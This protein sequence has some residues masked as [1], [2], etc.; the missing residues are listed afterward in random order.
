MV[1]HIMKFYNKSHLKALIVFLM[2]L[3]DCPI[4]AVTTPWYT[5]YFHWLNGTNYRSNCSMID[6]V[7]K[8]QYAALVLYYQAT[9]KTTDFNNA[10]LNIINDLKTVQDNLIQQEQ[11]ILASIKEKYGLSDDAWQKCLLDINEL[12]KVYKNGMLQSHHDTVHDQDIPDEIMH[13]LI[14]LL[15]ENNINPSSINICMASQEETAENRGTVALAR[16]VIF[17]P[18]IDALNNLVFS[19]NYSPSTIVLFPCI[20]NY[21]ITEQIGLCAHEIQH[22]VSLHSITTFVVEKYLEHHCAINEKDFEKSPE[23]RELC[24]IHEAQADILS[25]INNPHVARCQKS[26]SKKHCYPNM[27]Y[28]EHFYTLAQID[29]LWKLHDRLEALYFS[30][31]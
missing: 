14:N 28:E 3:T 18:T 10:L 26:F 15:K 27:L 8:I 31:A 17:L 24:Q 6:S 9:H 21:P 13:P 30:A 25:A 12:K 20:H 5:R 11:E 29:M 19:Q 23:Y 1:M 2:L 4:S 16:S 7:Q 22:L